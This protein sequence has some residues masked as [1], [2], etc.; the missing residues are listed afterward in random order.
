[1]PKWVRNLVRNKN[2]E[3]LN[4]VGVDGVGGV[5]SVFFRYFSLVFFFHFF[6]RFSSVFFAFFILLCFSLILL[7]NKGKRLQFTAIIMNNGEIHSDPVCTD[8]VQNFPEKNKKTF[9]GRRIL[10]EIGAKFA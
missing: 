2:W 3:V 4:G 9:S 8:P 5:F 10:C 1:M 7:E 6:L